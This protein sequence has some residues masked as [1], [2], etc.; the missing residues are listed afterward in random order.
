MHN[1]TTWNENVFA[2]KLNHWFQWYLSLKRVG[3]HAINSLLYLRILGE[4][5]IKSM[6]MFSVN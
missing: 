1:T 3:H 4:K 5:Y 2:V 6:K